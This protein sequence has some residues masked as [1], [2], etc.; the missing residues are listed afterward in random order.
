[1]A[2]KNDVRA[3]RRLARERFGYEHLRPGQEEAIE[4]VLDGRDTLAVMPTGGGKSAIYQL[5]GLLLTG[6]TVVVS[7][8]LA[9]QRDQV[10]SLDDVDGG[11]AAEVNSRVGA[12]ER[13]ETLEAV[14]EDEIEFVFM[15]PEQLANQ[16]TLTP[17]RE[18][19][20]SLFVVDEA[21]CVS[22]WATTFVPNTFA[23]VP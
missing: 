5:A 16:D 9:L 15:T 22:E 10:E 6:S 4:A 7:P 11:G 2:A 1:M 3:A 8:L 20:P 19:P 23:S 12:G 14:A 17:L 21:H 13:R 18:S